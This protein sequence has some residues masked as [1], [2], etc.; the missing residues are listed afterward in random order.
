MNTYGMTPLFSQI[1]ASQWAVPLNTCIDMVIMSIDSDLAECGINKQVFIEGGE[2]KRLKGQCHEIF[3]FWF[4]HE[5]VSP[6]PVSI[7]LGSFQIFS[8]IRGDIR[9]SRFATGVNDTGGKC[10]KSSII[11]VLII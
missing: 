8:K 11:K 3:D 1:K 4:F 6:K 10:K 9:C 2:A 5:S 7:P